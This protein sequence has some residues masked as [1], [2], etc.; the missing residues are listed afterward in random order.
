[1]IT[2]SPTLI[3]LWHKGRLAPT[4]RLLQRAGR[5]P[6]TPVTIITG[7]Q[8]MKAALVQ[9]GLTARDLEEYRT[10]EENYKAAASEESRLL[11][12]WGKIC[13]L[14]GQTLEE[15]TSYDG[16]SLWKAM[17][18]N[19]GFAFLAPLIDRL[20]L[21]ER[22]LDVERPDRAILEGGT[23]EDR[24]LFALA[25][26]ARGIM[27][28]TRPAGPV[29]RLF[30]K[31]SLLGRTKSIRL[32]GMTRYYW[33]P[34]CLLAPLWRTKSLFYRCVA[35]WANRRLRASDAQFHAVQP[36]PTV[37]FLSVVQRFT[38]IILPVIHELQRR[39]EYRVLVLDRRFS[40]GRPK[41]QEA[42]IPH[43][44][45]EGYEGR[46]VRR[47][48]RR[49]ARVFRR[50]W[51][52]LRRDKV[53]MASFRWR[54]LPL[55]DAVRRRLQDNFFV[56]FP[57]LVQIIETARRA[58]IVERPE[59]VVVTDERPPFQRAFVE[60][61][62]SLRIPTLN[63]QNAVI[64]EYP[65]GSPISTRRMAVDGE[66]FKEVL[67]KMG[68]DHR[69]IIVTGQPRFDPLV[70]G[71]RRFQREAIMSRLGLDPRKK[72]IVLFPEGI[73]TGIREGDNDQFIRAT[74]KAVRDLPDVQVVM[75]LHP[76]DFEFVRPRRF[77]LEAGLN[78]VAIVKDVDLWD[79]L[80]ISDVALVTLS[81][82]GHEA[83][84]MGRP[85][86]QVSISK[87]EPTYIQYAELGAALEVTDVA[88]LGK[89]IEKALWD[90]VT[91][92][93]LEEGRA[94]YLTHFAHRLDGRASERVVDL[95]CQMIRG[96]A[97]QSPH[98]E[99]TDAR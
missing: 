4:L 23:D 41:L 74:F 53:A 81:T 13:F 87:T 63:I 51:A 76:I 57:E 29:S 98:V 8:E 38:D 80:S 85:L 19:F 52:L 18:T 62:H 26:R 7:K 77:A 86:I 42:R 32:A 34:S 22:V 25:A 65:L 11:E 48:V 3:V 49:A 24:L 1:M 60:A 71:D 37:L 93:R 20:Q 75:K 9:K 12:E 97:A 82:V 73:E 94:N 40:T 46:T 92:R 91:L 56:G 45:L 99:E 68:N 70:R 66:Y 39:D 43:R 78:D 16:I 83:I 90:P 5:E 36:R 50:R 95:I 89:T 10:A 30:T 84:A 28:E 96:S 27:V 44:L 59:I 31:L 64:F 2:Q 88:A 67:V 54:N 69:K 14:D 6:D 15:A 72:V 61:A 58:F 79:L 47:Q 55:W 17:E 33:V 21:I 35:R